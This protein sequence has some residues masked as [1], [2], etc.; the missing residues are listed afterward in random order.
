M[1]TEAARAAR[2][3]LEAYLRAK[4]AERRWGA[5]APACDIVDLMTDLLLLAKER[6]YDPCLVIGQVERHLNAETGLNR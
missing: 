6:G 1:P 5:G 4:G 3:A 2:I